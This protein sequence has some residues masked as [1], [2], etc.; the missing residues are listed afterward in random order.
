MKEGR[1]GQPGQRMGELFGHWSD[2]KPETTTV[3]LTNA[4]PENVQCVG[5]LQAGHPDV[6][7]LCL[8]RF[9]KLFLDH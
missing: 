9:T 4:I 2:T 1:S 3:S 7:K 6:D 5:Q 8:L